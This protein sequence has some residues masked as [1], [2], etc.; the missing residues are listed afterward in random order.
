MLELKN[1]TVAYDRSRT[2]LQGI[3]LVAKSGEITVLLGQNGS[4]KSTLF[5]TVLGEIPYKGDIF[6][7]GSRL[8]DTKRSARA[9]LLALL[10][11]HLPAPALSVKEAVMLGLSHR[12]KHPGEAEWR[13]VA[14]KL[15]AVGISAL[16]DRPVNTLSG[17]ERQKV[18]LALMLAHDAPVLLLDEPATYTD[19]PFNHRLFDLLCAERDKGKTVL[20]V[21]HDVGAAL[22]L[23]DRIVLLENGSVAFDGTPS[24][25]LA[26]EIPEKHFGLTR[27]TAE[28]DGKTAYFF[29]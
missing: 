8:A 27:Y 9:A 2:V 11:Q 4:G 25:A 15:E 1:V 28:R 5:H 18:F 22:N 21:M 13:F 16:S 3:D 29:K 24:E 12:C 10:P 6:C 7:C 19:A 23:A 17:G 20:L 14:E 26:R